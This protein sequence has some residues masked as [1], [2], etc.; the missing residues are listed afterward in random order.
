MALKKNSASTVT[1][2]VTINSKALRRVPFSGPHAGHLSTPTIDVS[3]TR[4]RENYLAQ[5]LQ[6][7]ALRL[8]SFKGPHPKVM[9]GNRRKGMA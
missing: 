7:L 1:G 6:L 3:G 9:K 4:S 8:I 5:P 2:I